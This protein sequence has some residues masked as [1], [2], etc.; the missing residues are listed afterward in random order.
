MVNLRFLMLN[1]RARKATP[2][3]EVMEALGSDDNI[4][5]DQ[6]IYNKHRTNTFYK[7]YSWNI[8]L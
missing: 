5:I 1:K 2:T 3:R 6:V 8:I 4:I 7:T